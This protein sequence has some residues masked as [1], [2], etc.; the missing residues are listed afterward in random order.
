MPVS[1]VEPFTR[2]Y[3][4]PNPKM[5]GH[6]QRE[7]F[8]LFVFAHAWEKPGRVRFPPQTSENRIIKFKEQKHLA[9]AVCNRHISQGI[10]IFPLITDVPSFQPHSS[11]NTQARAPYSRSIEWR[12][13]M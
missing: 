8:S 13:T 1:R 7:W 3:K 6:S 11:R 9:L 10:S 5:D 2:V 12:A 4:R